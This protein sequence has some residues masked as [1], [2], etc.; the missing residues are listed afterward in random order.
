MN[1]EVDKKRRIQIEKEI[2]DEN[3]PVGI[4]AKE[5][6]I[7]IINKLIEIEKRLEKLEHTLNDV[8]RGRLLLI[9]LYRNIR[10]RFHKNK[11]NNVTEL[12]QIDSDLANIE[13]REKFVF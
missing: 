8:H 7:I 6:H 10:N 5:T 2:S 1:I 4:D 11:D 9:T 13:K 3:S 12:K